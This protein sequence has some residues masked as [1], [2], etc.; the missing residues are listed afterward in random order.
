[1]S[2]NTANK[3]RIAKN[4]LMLY[5]RMLFTIAVT[6]YTSRVILQTLGIEDYGIYNVVA[7]V[8]ALLGFITNSLGNAHSRFINIAIAE[9]DEEKQ[10]ETFCSIMTVQYIMAI[11]ILITAE[12]AGLWFVENK[13]VIPEG[14]QEAAMW[15]YQGAVLTSVLA[16][17]TTPYN[18]LIIAH[19]KISIYA[20]VTMAEA[21]AKLAVAYLIGFS[22]HDKL[23]LYAILLT[24]VQLSATATYFT[25]CK[26]KFIELKYKFRLRKNGIRHIV[27]FSSWAMIGN[28]ALACCT[29]GF[30]I[31]LNLFFGPVANAA[32]GIATQVEHGMRQFFTS[33]QTATNPQIIQSY[34]SGNMPS[35]HSLILH[36][37]KYSFYLSMFVFLPIMFCAEE[38][39]QLWLV[40][41]PE[42][43][44]AFV[45]I[46]IIAALNYAI[47]N[48]T[49][50]AIRATGN[51]RN[52]ELTVSLTLL[53]ALPICYLLLK[54]MHLSAAEALIV[55]CAI[56][57]IAQFIRVHITF[58][59]INLPVKYYY[60]KVLFPI[61]KVCL[62]ACILP[63]AISKMLP[64]NAHSLLGVVIVFFA[65]GIST[66]ISAYAFGLTKN[67]RNFILSKLK[68]LASNKFRL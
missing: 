35:M 51:I 68:N 42:N 60:T 18:A 19:E 27:S 53:A 31:L 13:L 66:I 5:I 17:V 40:N 10:K 58:P 2:V 49:I 6:F 36:S 59:R 8:I 7:G 23:P 50:T 24:C 32:K 47:G 65:C 54:F 52:F 12:T 29:Q 4:T 30:N 46:T 22:G 11:I 63:F 44:A 61:I 57:C 34:A 3:K 55:Y 16:F 21:A 48:S 1:M 64:S 20:Y 28:I 56:E 9:A 62:F 14:R 25:Y 26:R 43:T 37:A 67:E 15:A 33:F 41:V 38:I 45:R 39:L